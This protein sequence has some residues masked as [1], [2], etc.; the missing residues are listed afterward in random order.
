MHLAET[1]HTTLTADDIDRTS[2]YATIDGWCA[3]TGMSRAGTYRGLG[4]GHLAGLKLGDRTL[5]DVRAGL[6]WM[7]TLP[8]AVIR[9]GRRKPA[10]RTTR[11]GA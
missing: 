4:R 10:D 5:I 2:R 11:P 6:A 7:R 1:D 8:P 3:L 9:T